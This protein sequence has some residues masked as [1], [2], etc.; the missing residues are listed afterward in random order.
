MSSS[1]LE[2]VRLIG[3]APRASGKNLDYLYYYWPEVLGGDLLV[4]RENFPHINIWV[5]QRSN[6]RSTCCPCRCEA[7]VAHPLQG[8][9]LMLL[10]VEDEHEFALKHYTLAAKDP[11]QRDL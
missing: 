7:P 3:Q 9:D 2:R 5:Y 10:A 6:F 11:K 1:S 8:G 4:D